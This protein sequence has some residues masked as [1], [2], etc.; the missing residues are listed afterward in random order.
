MNEIHLHVP[1]KINDNKGVFFNYDGTSPIKRK[2]YSNKNQH[3]DNVGLIRIVDFLNNKKSPL[4]LTTRELGGNSVF[5]MKNTRQQLIVTPTGNYKI[6][7]IKV[8][9]NAEK[10]LGFEAG[11]TLLFNIPKE[12]FNQ[13]YECFRKNKYINNMEKLIFYLT[14]NRIPCIM[15]WDDDSGAK[16][17]AGN[18]KDDKIYLNRKHKVISPIVQTIKKLISRMQRKSY[19]SVVATDTI[20]NLYLGVN[21]NSQ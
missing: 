13:K 19:E 7:D 5:E 18:N 15:V 12:E 9:T 14:S 1:D 11:K 10:I 4:T 16:F 3:Q 6:K 17:I 8:Y 2:V 21:A 20:R